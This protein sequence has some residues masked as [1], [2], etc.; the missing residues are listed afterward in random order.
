MR[1]AIEKAARKTIKRLQEQVGELPAGKPTR[2]VCTAPTPL[3]AGDLYGIPL[4]Y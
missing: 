1:P 2:W 4:Y 3:L